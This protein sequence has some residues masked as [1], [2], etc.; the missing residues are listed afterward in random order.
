MGRVA[1]PAEVVDVHFERLAVGIF[2][3]KPRNPG[4]PQQRGRNEAGIRV[5][6]RLIQG[7]G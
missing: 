1:L 3:G 6:Y 4:F 2:V 5:P 7:Q